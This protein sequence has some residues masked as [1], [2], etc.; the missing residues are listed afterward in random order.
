MG[1]VLGT[2]RNAMSTVSNE[3]VGAPKWDGEKKSAPRYDAKFT[4]YAVCSELGDALNESMM[5]TMV[6]KSEYDALTTS[7]DDK[8]K[9]LLWKQNQRL[10]ALFVLG[11]ESDH[12]L[13]LFSK[14][15]SDEF[16][17]GRVIEALRA[18][19]NKAKPD[20]ATAMLELEASL[21]ALK[22]AR[23]D[24]YYNDVVGVQA[25]FRAK[26]TDK[27]L[28]M[29][30]AKKVNS[31]TFTKMILDHLADRSEPD[32]LEKL[33]NKICEIQRLSKTL[34]TA[35]KSEQK[36][37][38][39]AQQ[40]TQPSGGN[41]GGGGGSVKNCWNCGNKCGYTKKTCPHPAKGG[42]KSGGGNI[43]CG[44]PPCGRTG[45]SEDKCWKKN[46]HLA[47]EWYKN[48]VKEA[49]GSSVEIVLPSVDFG[50]AR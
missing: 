4:A 48:K 43:K 33:C 2:L 15:V 22:F 10:G 5:A 20:D 12:G 16:P 30:M 8:K 47:P 28:I 42:N 50:V 6:N 7:D 24:D 38:Q 44:Y 40:P 34:G 13:D 21:D 19:R 26:K 39:L 31:Q 45:H 46:P 18:L 27:E 17:H 23:A 14:T 3:R 32:N 1:L 36:E 25:R 37:V 35:P 41:G 11:Q 9:A 29:L 49:Q